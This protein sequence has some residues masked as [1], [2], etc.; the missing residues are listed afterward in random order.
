M[1]S[2]VYELRAEGRLTIW[3][4]NIERARVRA[5]VLARQHG[6]RVDLIKVWVRDN[7]APK[8]LQIA[9][10]N[11]DDWWKDRKK[12]ESFIPQPTIAEIAARVKYENP[13][14]PESPFAEIEGD[15]GDEDDGGSDLT[16]EGAI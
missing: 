15:H 1:A 9:M 13:Q 16:D 10:L 8:D 6:Q 2:I 5:R 12:I 7:I 4:R 14:E 3:V 11:R